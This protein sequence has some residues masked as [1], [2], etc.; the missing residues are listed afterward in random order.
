MQKFALHNQK[1]NSW[2]IKSKER[3]DHLQ[4][5]AQLNT[6]MKLPIYDNDAELNAEWLDR[7]LNVMSD[8]YS[9]FPDY[10]KH[11]TAP[12]YDVLSREVRIIKKKYTPVNA[13]APTPQIA[14][15]SKANTVV[16][17]ETAKA[18]NLQAHEVDLKQ[19]K[20]AYS[21]NIQQTLPG[22]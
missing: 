14:R 15:G 7:T 13:K 16:A 4:R 9:T 18:R 10:A 21:E 6:L 8:E 17:C 3:R 19:K 22:G 5:R 12:R 2:E 1:C 20:L 11:A